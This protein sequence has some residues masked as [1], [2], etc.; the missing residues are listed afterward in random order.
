MF[1]DVYRGSHVLVLGHT[2]FKGSWLCSWLLELGADVTGGSLGIPTKP[3]LFEV[4]GLEDRLT[5]RICD[6]RDANAL[7]QLVSEVQP[8]FVFFLAAQA[9]VSVSYENPIETIQTNVLGTANILQALRSLK[10]Q[11]SAVIITSDKCYENVEWAWGYKETDHLGGKDIYSASKGAA[12]IV[13]HAYTSSFFIGH[14]VR[15]ATARAG[16]VIG[17]GDWSTDRIV[18]DC[19]RSW[20]D[21]NC[22]KIRSPSATRPWQHVLE[23]L[24]GYLMLGADLYQR[25]DLHGESFNFGP[26]AESPIT[27]EKLIKDLGVTWE[28]S[29][30][31][32]SYEVVDRVPFN[33]AG[34]LKLNCDKALF[35]LS[36]QATLTYKECIDY[37]G[38]W[39]LKYYS[40]EEKMRDLT[41]RQIKD[42]ENRGSLQGIPWSH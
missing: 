16:N 17:G 8:D 6:V 2:G 33:E 12:E 22:V 15:I 32:C 13:F 24:S 36:W 42:F 19:V 23:P 34:L 10:K 1:S 38:L 40:G 14:P 20:A 21:N 11:C 3:S 27:V 28:E 37:V 30:F 31:S 9:I 7:D 26:K 39:Y 5:H 35:H 29:S 25:A 18:V 41:V 4:A